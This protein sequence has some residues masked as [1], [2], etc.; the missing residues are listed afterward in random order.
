VNDSAAG[1]IRLR[2]SIAWNEI[3]GEIVL[4][5]PTGSA[6]FSV[7]GAGTALWPFVVEGS[8]LDELTDCLT[9]RFTLDRSVAERDVRSFLDALNEEG[10]LESSPSS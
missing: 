1:P 6:Y 4:L 5:D 8:T 7:K 3:D 10:L 9:E 2:E